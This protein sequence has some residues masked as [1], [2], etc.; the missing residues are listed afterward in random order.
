MPK[1]AEL[2]DDEWLLDSLARAAESGELW[3]A[4]AEVDELIKRFK[5]L[6]RES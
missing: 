3:K 5:A 6:K 4:E 1:N 2:F